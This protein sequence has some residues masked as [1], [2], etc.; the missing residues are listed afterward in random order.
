VRALGPAFEVIQGP[1]PL[2]LVAPHGGRRDPVL[3][4][5]TAGGLRTNDLHTAALT[6]ELA[7]ATAASALL[8]VG[9]DRNDVDLNRV[10]T[11]HDEAP[12]FLEALAELLE[13]ALDCHGHAVV[14]TIHGWN[15]VQAAVDLGIGYRP[16]RHAPGAPPGPTASP[17]F[18]GSALGPLRHA[19]D[20]RGITVSFG[21]RYPARA[22][23]NLL[24]LFTTRY[25][26]DPRPLVRRLAGLGQR[27]E[28]VQLELGL[29]LR[30]PGPWRAQLVGGLVDTVPALL[31][32]PRPRTDAPA[33][34]PEPVPGPLQSFEFVSPDL[35]GLAALDRAGGRLLL[36]EPDGTLALFTGERIGGEPPDRVGGLTLRRA[37]DG[38]RHLRYEGPLVRFPDTTPFLDL[39]EGLAGATLLDASL[40]LDYRPAHP[41]CPFGSVAGTLTLAG[42]HRLIA[43]TAAADHDDPRAHTTRRVAL[44]LSA[45]ERLFV[46]TDGAAALIG[47]LCR[48]GE[49]LPIV[50]VLDTSEGAVGEAPID[51]R[52][53]T[54]ERCVVEVRPL[55]RLPVVRGGS[56]PPVRVEFTSCRLATAAVP[57]GWCFSVLPAPPG[58]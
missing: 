22:R 39:E 47:Y 49:H 1:T 57:A 50:E 17:A 29:P 28:G 41:G 16:G 56:T 5:W 24:Q 33:I 43:G 58:V 34:V 21:A 23:E 7:T 46:R 12:R 44:E 40:A 35:C 30:W 6:R 19:L 45:G 11:A 3:R 51:V 27:C 48:A 4:P 13:A 10:S 25:L 31:G 36:F 8:N 55:H 53:A 2:V 42:R 54:G 32:H 15:V 14:L 18:V 26:D 20:R 38:T 9:L 37:R 52:L